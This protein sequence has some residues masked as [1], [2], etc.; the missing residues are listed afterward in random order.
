MILNMPRRFALASG[1]I[2]LLVTA[3][4][5]LGG[6]VFAQILVGQE[7]SSETAVQG[8]DVEVSFFYQGPGLPT[9]ITATVQGVDVRDSDGA[10]DVGDGLIVDVT[11]FATKGTIAVSV[12][13]GYVGQNADSGESSELGVA[14]LTYGEIIMTWVVL[15]FYD[16]ME[17]VVNGGITLEVTNPDPIEVMTPDPDPLGSITIE[18][19]VT[20]VG[21]PVPPGPHIFGFDSVA[22]NP[23]DLALNAG[24]GF[25]DLAAGDYDVAEARLP[26]GW[27]FISVE[28]ASDQRGNLAVGAG[29]AIVIGLL[30]GENVVCLYLNDFVE[31]DGDG[32]GNG[33]NGGGG[34]LAPVGGGGGD[35]EGAGGAPAPTGG[36]VAGAGGGTGTG[37][38]TPTS[39]PDTGSGGLAA[40]GGASSTW[41]LAVLMALGLMASVSGASLALRRTRR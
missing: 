18:K 38:A 15:A 29:P 4:A 34:A 30:A 25:P 17:L 20:L 5:V 1:G 12:P 23:F 8:A 14:Q 31:D 9:R 10:T 19:D 21:P 26:A 35:G 22:L 2:A 27:F 40:D 11:R 36:G 6:S 33:G 39:L 28:C 37:S 3:M 16:G 13:E 32:G 41:L 24:I 7:V